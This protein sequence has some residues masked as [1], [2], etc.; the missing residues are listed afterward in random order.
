VKEE[1]MKIDEK[2]LR[3]IV[4]EELTALNEAVDHEGAAKVSRSAS[5]LLKAVGKFKEAAGDGAVAA[6][7]SH[8]VALEGTLENMVS[9][10]TSYVPKVR[11]EPKR[12]SLRAVKEA[13]DI[14]QRAD[15]ISALVDAEAKGQGFPPR[16]SY[17]L[18]KRFAKMNN[19]ELQ[20]AY[21][22]LGMRSA[23]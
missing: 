7:S 11:Q 18:R 16:P 20:A 8:L 12:V 5:A 6:V 2:R 15:M 1:E 19:E 13:I 3:Q 21:D 22:K 4:N 14:E 10:P 23:S 17:A 9:A